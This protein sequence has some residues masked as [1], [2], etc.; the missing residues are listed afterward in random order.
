MALNSRQTKLYTDTVDI[1][2]PADPVPGELDSNDIMPLHYATAATYS[3]QKCYQETRPEFE[4]G[5]FHG[6]IN[7]EQTESLMDK[8]HFDVALTI[9]PN[10]VVKLKTASDPNINE[11]YL[12]MGDSM[13]KNYRANKQVFFAKKVIKPIFI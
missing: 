3:D 7:R 11:Y 12:L 6:R 2:N 1:W 10:A 9:K 8:F 5:T 13:V 4:Q